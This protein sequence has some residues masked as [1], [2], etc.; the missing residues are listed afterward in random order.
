MQPPDN[1]RFIEIVR[2][3]LHFDAVAHGQANKAFAHLAGN[4]GQHQVFIVQLDTKH[5][6]R[7][8]DRHAAFYFD[9]RF[10]DRHKIKNGVRFTRT[11]PESLGF[12]SSDHGRRRRHRHDNRRRHRHHHRGIHGDRRRRQPGALRGGARR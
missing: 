7:Q 4:G 8:N 12:V 1:A 2:G 9:M 5:G 3:H 6:A 11:P 10:F